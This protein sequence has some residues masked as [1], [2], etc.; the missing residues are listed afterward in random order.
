MTFIFL[1]IC[2]QLS[3]KLGGNE[4]IYFYEYYLGDEIATSFDRYGYKQFTNYATLSYD[5]R[6]DPP[7]KKNLNL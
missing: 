5:T 6:C 1:D 4:T 7:Y 3:A 2:H